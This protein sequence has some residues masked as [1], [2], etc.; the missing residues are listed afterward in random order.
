M[1]ASECS[2]LPP[3]RGHSCPQQ[4][5][6]IPPIYLCSQ[7]RSSIRRC[8]GQE[9]PR[10]GVLAISRGALAD[11]FPFSFR[12]HAHKS[13]GSHTENVVPISGSVATSILPP[14]AST[15]AL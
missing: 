3:E 7:S 12:P 11:R 4:A 5:P 14:C 10:S 15:I 2:T 1:F 6:T 8:C 13:F 9:C